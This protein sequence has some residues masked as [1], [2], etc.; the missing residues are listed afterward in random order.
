[1]LRCKYSENDAEQ[2]FVP[3]ILDYYAQHNGTK[4]IPFNHGVKNTFRAIAKATLTKY[5]STSSKSTEINHC[6][7]EKVCIKGNDEFQ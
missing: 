1:M 3:C 6:A 5:E 7:K 4:T 2:T